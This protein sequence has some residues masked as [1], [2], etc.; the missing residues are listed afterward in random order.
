MARGKA[1]ALSLVFCAAVLTAYAYKN[2]DVAL[3]FPRAQQLHAERQLDAAATEYRASIDAGENVAYAHYNL[4]LIRSE[5]QRWPEAEAELRA[6]VA[7]APDLTDAQLALGVALHQQGKMDDAI[8]E[9]E[10][11]AAA[12]PASSAAFYDLGLAH[13]AAGRFDRALDAYTKAVA[14]DP[15]SADA[16]FNLGYL[17][18]HNLG[19]PQ[20][21]VAHFR[22]AVELNPKM[23]KAVLEMRAASAQTQR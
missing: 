21:A 7:G 6:A 11:V 18:A 2:R 13:A 16:E 4:G 8:R 1:W 9:Y 12:N 15:K 23:E 3:H 22:R 20:D 17:L 14:L 19:R 10:A 5:Q